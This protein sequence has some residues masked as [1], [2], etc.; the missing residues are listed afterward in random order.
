MLDAAARRRKCYEP[1]VISSTLAA[2]AGSLD[3]LKAR[4]R[5]GCRRLGAGQ[6]HHLV[7][8]VGGQRRLAGFAAGLPQQDIN[9]MLGETLLPAPHRWAADAGLPCDLMHRQS[10]CRE[11][12]DQSALNLLERTIA[13]ADDGGQSLAVLGID[14]NADCLGHGSRIARS[15]V[16][17]DPLFASVH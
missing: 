11:H 13:V 4:M 8:G 7:D 17:W 9:P 16:S 3:F 14:D 5:W 6:R 12:D 15:A 2:K 10:F 1:T